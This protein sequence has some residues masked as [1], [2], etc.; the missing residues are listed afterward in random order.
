MFGL[1]KATPGPTTAPATKVEG[2]KKTSR[3]IEKKIKKKIEIVPN[4]P[5]SANSNPGAKAHKVNF[6][7]LW[8][9]LFSRYLDLITPVIYAWPSF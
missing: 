8:Q 1:P 2:S 5:E 3:T 6:S 4:K 9:L 7:L